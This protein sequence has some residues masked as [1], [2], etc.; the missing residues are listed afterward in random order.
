MSDGERDLLYALCDGLLFTAGL[1][2]WREVTMN[3]DQRGLLRGV[4]NALLLYV[5]VGLALWLW[6]R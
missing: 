3:D 1:R 5:T 4:R 6:L 2:L